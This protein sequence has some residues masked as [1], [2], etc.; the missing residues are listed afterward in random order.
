MHPKAKSVEDSGCQGIQ[1]FH[2]NSETP[3]KKNKKN[4]LTKDDKKNNRTLSRVRVYVENVIG[5]IKRFK[6]ITDKYRNRRR[7][8][9]LRFNLI[10]AI[11]NFEIIF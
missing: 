7:R 6:I 10:A 4:P 8:F 5:L 11:C 2:A 3:K 1:K 9:G